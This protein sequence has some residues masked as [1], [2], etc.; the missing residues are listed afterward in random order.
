MSR[1]KIPTRV[2]S[3]PNTHLPCGLIIEIS[4]SG[5]PRHAC[6]LQIL[7]AAVP[8]CSVPVVCRHGNPSNRDAFPL[9]QVLPRRSH[10]L[11][12]LAFA[13]CPSGVSFPF[14]GHTSLD[15]RWPRHRS[16]RRSIP[17]SLRKKQRESPSWRRRLM[18][19]RCGQYASTN[20][21]TVAPG[22][23]WHANPARSSALSSCLCERI[24]PPY[25]LHRRA[26][27][28]RVQ[29]A[30][31][32]PAGRAPMVK[33]ASRAK[34]ARKDRAWPAGRRKHGWRRTIC[35]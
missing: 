13:G 7:V 16:H 19:S 32:V 4:G 27:E 30:S 31:S 12:S 15:R 28:N 11:S 17:R 34:E 8:I 35:I 2:T 10:T 25:P 14:Q 33:S 9:L 29:L 24:N 26:A 18:P 6:G 20:P 5:A 22:I 21:V 23:V 1:Q 3:Q